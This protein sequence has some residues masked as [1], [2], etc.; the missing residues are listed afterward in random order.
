MSPDERLYGSAPPSEVRARSEDRIDD[1][2]LAT[3]W[4]HETEPSAKRANRYDTAKLSA[5]AW[6]TIDKFREASR[7]CGGAAARFQ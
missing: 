6:A 2:L 4:R 3:A 1:R 7:H 5:F